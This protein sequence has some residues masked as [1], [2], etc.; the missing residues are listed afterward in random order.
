MEKQC[1]GRPA[2][3][4]HLTNQFCQDPFKIYFTEVDDTPLEPGSNIYLI[5]LNF[6]R[7]S[8]L[9]LWEVCPGF[10]IVGHL[11]AIRSWIG[12]VRILKWTI[13]PPLPQQPPTLNFE[14]VFKC[15]F[16]LMPPPPPRNRIASKNPLVAFHLPIIP[17]FLA[18]IIFLH[19]IF[20][21][22][23]T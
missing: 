8:P 6:L 11:E 9:L 20:E 1:H 12:A 19:S 16:Q 17:Q 4:L 5:L 14:T 18:Q 22:G 21:F 7:F 15:L 2:I 13:S 23:W 3:G 10:G